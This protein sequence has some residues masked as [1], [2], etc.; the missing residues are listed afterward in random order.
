MSIFYRNQTFD[1]TTTNLTT[2][3]TIAVSA[4]AIVKTVQAVHT[5]AADVQTN[6]FIK[7][8]GVGD[9]TIATENIN[10]ATVDMITNTLNLDVTVQ[11]SP[12]GLDIMQKVMNQKNDKPKP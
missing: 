10:K 4:I 1:L 6:L 5:V 2:V 11:V 3:L 8:P 9:V 7:K 12:K